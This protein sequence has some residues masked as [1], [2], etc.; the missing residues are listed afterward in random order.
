MPIMHRPQKTTI[1]LLGAG[2]PFSD[3]VPMTTEAESAEVMK[4][5]AST[6][7][8]R[9]GVIVPSGRLSNSENKT[10]SE[11]AEP[12]NPGMFSRLKLIAV[13]PKI[14][15]ARM[16]INVGASVVTSAN[17]R[18]VRPREIRAMNMPTNGVH[19]IHH[20]Q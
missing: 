13:P 8:M 5:T 15:N 9:N 16:R 2:F 10:F 11:V 12:S 19:A 6:K 1:N 14:V 3:R 17:W 18:I 20:A 4:K 7:M